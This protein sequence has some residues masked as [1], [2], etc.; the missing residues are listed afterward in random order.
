MK[1]QTDQFIIEA[2]KKAIELN[3]EPDFLLLLEE[4]LGRRE[5][6]IHRE[7]VC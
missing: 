6:I 1:D 5:L 2:Y 3:L 7:A 4:E